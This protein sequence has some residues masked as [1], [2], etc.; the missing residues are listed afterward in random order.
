MNCLI[1]WAICSVFD[2][3]LIGNDDGEDV[4]VTVEPVKD[5]DGVREVA[6]LFGSFFT[7]SIDSSRKKIRNKMNC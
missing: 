7:S 2:V 5:D 4:T 3:F 6:A 1:I